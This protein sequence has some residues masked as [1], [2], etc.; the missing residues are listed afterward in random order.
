MYFSV[1]GEI[2]A[3]EVI[4]SGSS[5]R[6][7]AVLQDKYGAGRWRKLKGL[8]QVRFADGRLVRAEVHWYEAHGIGR[9]GFKIKRV[10]GEDRP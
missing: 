1:V 7:L 9:K 3:V 8:A 6:R 4:A 10:L 2:T 5:V